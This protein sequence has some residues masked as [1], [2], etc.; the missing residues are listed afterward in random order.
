[1]SV[2]LIPAASAKKAKTAAVKSTAKRTAAKSPTTN[3]KG[4]KKGPGVI[5]TVI[6]TISRDKGATA[7]EILAVL[8]KKFP[9]RKP[10]SMRKT[11]LIQANKTC[12]SKD[13]DEKRGKI[14]FRRGRS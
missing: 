8:V 6:E 3:K 9:D 1:M 13:T 10:D 7:D 2:Y 4:E 11:V 14:Y 5:A 12:T